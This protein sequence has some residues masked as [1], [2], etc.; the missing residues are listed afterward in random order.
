M[1][2]RESVIL[3]VNSE[4]DVDLLQRAIRRRF[5]G[6]NGI[7]VQQT[8]D[9]VT[10][11]G[12]GEQMR[13]GGGAGG[14]ASAAWAKVTSIT[15]GWECKAKLVDATGAV[16]GD[17]FFVYMYDEGQS[18]SLTVGQ[19][20]QIVSLPEAGGN[21]VGGWWLLAPIPTIMY[22]KIT[23]IT[24]GLWVKFVDGSGTVQGTAFQL[25]VMAMGAT[26]CALTTNFATFTPKL[27]V[28]GY[29]WAQLLPGAG[30]G[31]P[32]GWYLMPP[33]GWLTGVCP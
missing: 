15:S 9:V 27:V 33:S 32:A 19:A 10:I 1:G 4:R 24:S 14:G 28:G 30:S 5:V 22:A 3:A 25:W 31:R 26:S 29:V 2:A 21:L 12:P 23:S 6:R 11:T 18:W 7:S 13:Q 17:E 8:P 20:I 16:V